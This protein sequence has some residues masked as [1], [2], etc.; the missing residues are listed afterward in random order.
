MDGS[1]SLIYRTG[2]VRRFREEGTW[3]K[4]Y[5]L[6]HVSVVGWRV[7]GRSRTQDTGEKE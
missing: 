3:T 6:P 2:D 5:T 1:H 7:E 4:V